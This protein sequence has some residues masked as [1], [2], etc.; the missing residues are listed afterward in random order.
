MIDIH[1]RVEDELADQLRA[2]ADRDYRTVTGQILHYIHAGIT[3]AERPPTAAVRRQRGTRIPADFHVTADMVAWAREHAPE[4]DGKAETE[5]FVD[6]WTASALPTSYKMNWAR[7]WQTWMRN[8]RKEFTGAAGKP[9][10]GQRQAETDNLFGDAAAD[11]IRRDNE[12]K[13][14]DRAGDRRALPPGESPVP[15]AGH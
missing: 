3:R 14:L 9:R 6:H 7:A 4:V 2:A 15:R 5:K 10:Y 13:A 1:I 11:A 8:S 12:R